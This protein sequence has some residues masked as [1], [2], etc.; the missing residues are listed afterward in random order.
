MQRQIEAAALG[1]PEKAA[2][3]SA[4]FLKA[5]EVWRRRYRL[6]ADFVGF[7]GHFE[8]RPVLPALAQV[9]IAQDMV[10][11]LLKRPVRLAAVTQA[12]F[13]S[14]VPPGHCLSVYASNPEKSGE[15]RLHLTSMA[16]GGPAEI[17]AA[18]LRL[19]FKEDGHGL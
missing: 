3:P 4:A 16:E 5:G 9:F 8:G 13:L 6:G 14:P 15:W 18:F 1:S 19:N 7:Q 2:P 10:R 17:D 12:K 11:T